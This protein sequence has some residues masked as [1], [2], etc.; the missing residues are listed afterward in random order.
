VHHGDVRGRRGVARQRERAKHAA[1]HVERIVPVIGQQE[2][3]L[4]GEAVDRA[5]GER[6]L[7]ERER[8]ARRRAK[9]RP[10]RRAD[11]RAL[12]GERLRLLLL[13]RAR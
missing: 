10:Q 6:H 13:R 9:H 1:P 7:G 5:E 8:D 3:V 11:A 2:R 4:D 12:C